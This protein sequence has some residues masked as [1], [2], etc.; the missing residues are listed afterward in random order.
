MKTNNHLVKIDVS[1]TWGIDEYYSIHFRT[2]LMFVAQKVKL[3]V[4]VNHVM[5]FTEMP[6]VTIVTTN[7]IRR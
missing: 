3:H 6:L 1:K 2:Y 4:V 5:L 7:V